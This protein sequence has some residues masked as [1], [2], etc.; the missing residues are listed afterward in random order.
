MNLLMGHIRCYIETNLTRDREHAS[1]FNVLEVEQSTC[2]LLLQD[3][4]AMNMDAICEQDRISG[5]L[6]WHLPRGALCP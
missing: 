3:K 5:F 2:I 1:R 4:L 6:N